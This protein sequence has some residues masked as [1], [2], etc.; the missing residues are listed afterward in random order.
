MISC[1]ADLVDQAGDIVDEFHPDENAPERPEMAEQITTTETTDPAA[2]PPQA[3]QDAATPA[4]SKSTQDQAQAPATKPRGRPKKAAD[5]VPTAP[6]PAAQ[7]PAPAPV[8]VPIAAP[9]GDDNAD[10]F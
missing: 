10:F 9:I 4:A 8:P 5:P 7:A 6:A 3:A 1:D 2:I